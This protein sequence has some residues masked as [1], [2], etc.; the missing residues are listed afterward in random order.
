[1]EQF[2]PPLNN[3]KHLQIFPT[4]MAQVYSFYF[5]LTF[6]IAIHVCINFFFIWKIS[7]LYLPCCPRVSPTWTGSH[8][9][10]TRSCP[11]LLLD[12]VRSGSPGKSSLWATSWRPW[13]SWPWTPAPIWSNA[14]RPGA[15]TRRRQA[16]WAPGWTGQGRRSAGWRETVR[17]WTPRKTDWTKFRYITMR[18]HNFL[19]YLTIN[20][21]KVGIRFYCCNQLV[22]KEQ[23]KLSFGGICRNPVY[24]TYS[25]RANDS[26]TQLH[27]IAFELYSMINPLKTIYFATCR[28][29]NYP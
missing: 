11:R 2:H 14:W 24:Y 17:I 10:Q 27:K 12:Q 1:M 21:I 26:R 9:T 29:R 13:R 6:F 23:E 18:I 16:S 3:R 7:R 22:R 20:Y 4:G 15:R 5:E 25:S 8:P 28:T 19:E